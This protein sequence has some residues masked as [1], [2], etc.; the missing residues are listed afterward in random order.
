LTQ[1]T[2]QITLQMQILLIT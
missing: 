2:S 1:T